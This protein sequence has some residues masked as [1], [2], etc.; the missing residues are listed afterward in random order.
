[1]KRPRT[2]GIIS[3][4]V[5]K[6]RSKKLKSLYGN[7]FGKITALSPHHTDNLGNLYYSCICECGNRLSV[8]ASSLRAGRTK[9]CG[10]I[11][12]THGMSDKLEYVNWRNMLSRCLEKGSKS[13]KYYGGR[14]ITVCDR[15]K[16][17]FK[18]FYSDMGK[19]PTKEHSIDR[20]DCNGDYSPD[21][22][23]WAT[24]KEQ[25]D[26]KRRPV[27]CLRV[28]QVHPEFGHIKTWDSAN[29]AEIDGGFSGAGISA[30]CSGS[31]KTHYGCFWTKI[32]N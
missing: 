19:R 22:C 25:Q 11:N 31:Q 29:K 10:C 24:R 6:L 13:F 3:Q 2:K 32:P 21:N 15:W 5:I 20:I 27:N 4:K 12:M 9:S 26:N 17:S 8:R 28:M 1:M 7:T 23:R 14:G 18:N 30:C 16:N